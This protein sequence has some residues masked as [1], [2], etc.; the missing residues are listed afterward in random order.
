MPD[1]PVPPGRNPLG[2]TCRDPK[3]LIVAV[4]M[5]LFYGLPRAAI[6]ARLARRQAPAGGRRG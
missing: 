5:T 4:L 3:L 1:H 2:R 6:D